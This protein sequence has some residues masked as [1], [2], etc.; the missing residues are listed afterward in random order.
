MYGEVTKEDV[1]PPVP[2]LPD[3]KPFLLVGLA[4]R[5]VSW[6]YDKVVLYSHVD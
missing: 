1:S 3:E 2:V 4:V 6:Q 5:Y